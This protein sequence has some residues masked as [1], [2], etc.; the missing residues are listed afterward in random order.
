MI[1]GR[2]GAVLTHEFG[3]S[4]AMS[5][6]TALVGAIHHVATQPNQPGG[7]RA[8]VFQQSGGLWKQV[9]KL[10]GSD[11]HAGSNFGWSVSL[12]GTTAL[13]GSNAIWGAGRAYLFTQ[14]GGAWR[15]VS[16]LK[17]AEP[18][19]DA[20]F[21]WWVAT[22]ADTAVVA[23]ASRAGMFGATGAVLQPGTELLPGSSLLSTGGG[24]RLVMQRRD[25]N[26]VLYTAS[27]KVV[28]AT[29]TGGHPGA[30][31]VMQRDGNS[32]VYSATGVPLWSTRTDDNRG[33]RALLQQDGQ[34]VIDAA[35]GMV[36]WGRN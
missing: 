31:A 8:Y 21:G 10:V 35:S 28:W 3:F 2:Q 23:E 26:L 17:S 4:V 12:S 14:A 33:A 19:A 32:V 27:N 25:G 18:S 16:E 29:R 11:T 15:Q 22:S 5:G 24:F 36:L 7:G 30:V 34:F 1:A 20:N 13:V 9:A 6:T